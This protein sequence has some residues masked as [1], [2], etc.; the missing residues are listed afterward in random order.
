MLSA[1]PNNTEALLSLARLDI[2]D[3]NTD[4]ARASYLRLIELD[5]SD[6]LA[7]AGLLSLSAGDPLSQEA[8]LKSLVSRYPQA[9]PLSFALGNL[10]A[11]QRRWNEAT[12][13]YTRALTAA[14]SGGLAEVSP[15]YA[16]NLAIALEQLN[17]PEQAYIYYREALEYSAGVAPGFDQNLLRSR[18]TYLEQRI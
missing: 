5:P 12:G 6:P 1:E 18:I 4:A 2:A 17:K 9:A 15:D 7:R 14:K 3:G 13:A 11:S 8:E 10:Y 16:F